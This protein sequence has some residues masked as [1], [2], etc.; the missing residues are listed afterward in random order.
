MLLYVRQKQVKNSIFLELEFSESESHKPDYE[1]EILLLH[2][3]YA[4]GNE[5]QYLD[6][7]LKFLQESQKGSLDSLKSENLGSLL[8]YGIIY[9]MNQANQVLDDATNARV[10]TYFEK[11][12]NETF[13]NELD[14]MLAVKMLGLNDFNNL[15]SLNPFEIAQISSCYEYV[16]SQHQKHGQKTSVSLDSSIQKSFNP[17][18]K[19]SPCHDQDIHYSCQLF[20][21]WSIDMNKILTKEM[22]LALIR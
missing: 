8:T 10:K 3:R 12:S 16:R 17:Y 6:M 7:I 22:V 1:N 9:I 11:L 4:A 5:K 19:K 14:L 18:T 15:Q 21:K 20:C 2:P 13:F